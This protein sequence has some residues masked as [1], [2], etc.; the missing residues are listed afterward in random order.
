MF[1]C[2]W[3]TNVK[4]ML[5]L[6]IWLPR[7]ECCGAVGQEAFQEDEWMWWEKSTDGWWNVC[8]N[9][10]RFLEPKCFCECVHA[11]PKLSH[12]ASCKTPCCGSRQLARSCRG[13][14]GFNSSQ[15]GL[16]PKASH[17]ALVHLHKN[18]PVKCLSSLQTQM[19]CV[20]SQ[21]ERKPLSAT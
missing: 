5:Q 13:H 1:S 17:P 9:S 2:H 18:L 19:S 6:P 21:G 20:L 16:T 3:V 4:V 12:T 8:L 15:Q 14:Y 7:W 11:K 10:L